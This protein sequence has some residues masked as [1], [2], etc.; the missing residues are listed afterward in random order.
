MWTNEKTST[1][2]SAAESYEGFMR[3]QAERELAHATELSQRGI[4]IISTSGVLVT[5]FLGLNALA[6]DAKGLRPGVTYLVVL[7]LATTMFILAAISGLMANRLEPYE[8]LTPGALDKLRKEQWADTDAD[9]L[10]VLAYSEIR[11]LGGLRSGNARKARYVMIGLLC[12]IVAVVF[13]AGVATWT[14]AVS[15]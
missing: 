10:S 11:T 14:F 3:R 6:V 2:P 5:L 7:A 8:V 15:A 1:V 9:A 4:G 12:E 13:M